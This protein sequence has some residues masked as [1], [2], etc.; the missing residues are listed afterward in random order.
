MTRYKV[1]LVHF[2]DADDPDAAIALARDGRDP[3]IGEA[4]V[5]GSDRP[6][7]DASL[8]LPAAAEVEP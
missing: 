2:V 5:W 7:L 4:F 8:D 3:I 1:N 6:L